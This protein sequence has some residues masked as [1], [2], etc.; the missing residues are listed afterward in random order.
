MRDI[1]RIAPLLRKLQV[2]WHQNPD[3]RFHQL[4]RWIA[5]N[6]DQFNTED[7]VVKKNIETLIRALK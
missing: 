5:G 4:V 7:D 3:L 2:L 6:T 1:R